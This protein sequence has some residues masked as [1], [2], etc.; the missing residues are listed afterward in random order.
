MRLLLFFLFLL[1]GLWVADRMFYKSRYSREVWQD[2]KQESQKIES[3]IRR[4][5]K[6]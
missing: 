3:D 4:W 5:T 6:F 1:G 2:M